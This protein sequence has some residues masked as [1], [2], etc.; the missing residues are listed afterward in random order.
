[1]TIRKGKEYGAIGP[2]PSGSPI[3]HSDA[4]LRAIIEEPFLRGISLP[5]VGLVGGDLCRTLGGPRSLAEL[6]GSNALIAAVDIVSVTADGKRFISVA[7]VSIGKL[8]GRNSV[9][10]MNAQWQGEL[11]LGP[12]SHPGDGLVDITSGRLPFRSRRLALKRARTGSHL[13]HPQLSSVRVG[14]WEARFDRAVAVQI[15]GESVGSF[16]TFSID[17]VDAALS[18]VV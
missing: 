1:V 7:H 17:V 10:I 2:L 5:T 15:D 8:F 14:H 4:E 18:V 9:A 11:D 16:R 12:R 13:P 6:E 3:A